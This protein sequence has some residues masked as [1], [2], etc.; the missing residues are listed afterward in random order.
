V[1]FRSARVWRNAA[2]A[3]LAMAPF[4]AVAPAFA[5]KPASA[6]ARAEP[7]TITAIPIDFDRDN[8]GRKEFGKLVWR[9]GLNLFSN[10]PYF[11]GF[12]ALAIDPSGKTML[13]IS[14][15]GIWLR[16][17]I[18][19]DGRKMK[20]LGN[21]VIGPLLG[22][23]GKPLLDD[24]ERDSE[25]MTLIDGGPAGGMAYVSFERHHRILRYPFSAKSFGPPTGSL[26]LPPGTKRMRANSGLEAIVLLRS[27]P[28][29]GTVVA[30]AENL[31]DTNG[32]L[33]GWLIGGRTPGQFALK[34]L[35][36]F[37][38]TDAAPLPD[39]GIV[40]LERR[41][42]YSEGIKMRIRRIAAKELKPG[43]LVTG[44]VLLEA[45]DSLDIDNMEGIAAHRSAGGETILTLISDDNYSV[46]QRTLLMQFA[47][48]N[49]KPALA[50]PQSR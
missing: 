27:G 4:L 16:G 9:G 1:A 42:R 45:T 19:Y 29:D 21:A 41:F 18:D 47:L 12:S 22:P 26:P 37:D 49:T 46:L 43:A 36:G 25:G 8:P 24:K 6:L 10:S 32:N 33:Q 14:D 30:F 50:E 40:V 44:D 3:I 34:R 35:E 5:D 31:T 15:A 38:V 23:D 28:L 13:A 7:L 2:A 17:T 20:G 48:P 11:G 39:G